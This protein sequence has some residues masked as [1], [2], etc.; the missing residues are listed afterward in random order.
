[1]LLKE[2]GMNGVNLEATGGLRVMNDALSRCRSNAPAEVH[3][4][5]VARGST[6]P[7]DQGRTRNAVAPA[8]RQAALGGRAVG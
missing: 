6:A 5:G 1:M 8:V 4:D 7:N 2:N 3:G